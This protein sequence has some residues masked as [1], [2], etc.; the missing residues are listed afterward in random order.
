MEPRIRLYLAGVTLLSI[1]AVLLAVPAAATAQSRFAV[2][3]PATR[4]AAPLDGR[5]LLLLSA[6]SEAE[7]RFQIGDGPTTQLV[8]GIDE[9]TMEAVG[10]DA[11]RRLFLN[12]MALVF[13]MDHAHTHVPQE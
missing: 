8:F 7:P 2:S 3:F 4:S 10:V 9:Q 11:L 1:L 5:L 6:N 13:R 12:E